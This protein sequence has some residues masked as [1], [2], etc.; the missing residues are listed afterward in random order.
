MEEGAK[1]NEG[2]EGKK[3]ARDG[4]VVTFHI[5]TDKDGQEPISKNLQ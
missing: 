3:N 5:R 1:G 4:N 2:K